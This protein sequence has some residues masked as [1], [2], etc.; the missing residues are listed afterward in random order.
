MNNFAGYRAVC[1]LF[2]AVCLSS[3]SFAGTTP[4]APLTTAQAV[5]NLSRSQAQSGYPVRLHG[6]ITYVDLGWNMMFLHCATGPIFVVL[7]R[8]VSHLR[9]G[10]VVLL[11][12]VTGSSPAGNYGQ[13]VSLRVISK[14]SLPTPKTASLAALSK[15]ADENDYVSTEGILRPNQ[16]IQGHAH[17]LLVDGD[18]SIPIVIPGGSNSAFLRLIGNR[19][20]VH[21][22]AGP[23][24]NAH[25]QRMGT[26]LY[27]Q[28]AKAIQPTSPKEKNFLQAPV[29]SIAS[30]RDANLSQRFLPAVHLRGR[31]LW[32]YSNEF[33][34][35][36]P[37]GTVLVFTPSANQVSSGDD[38]DIVGFPVLRNNHDQIVDARIHFR[39]HYPPEPATPVRLSLAQAL[40]HGENGETAQMSGT[41]VA[42]SQ[43]NGNTIYQVADHR[44]TFEIMAGGKKNA[45]E[46]TPI[47]SPGS[48]IQATGTLRLLPGRNRHRKSV[49]LLVNSP[50]NIVIKSSSGVDWK[51]FFFVITGS[52]IWGIL[53]WV[54]QL[55]RTLRAKTTLI[56]DQMLQEA[57]LED[58]YR[59]LFERSPT[60]IFI[61]QPSGKITDCNPAFARMLEFESP[62]QVIGKSY[63]SLLTD[64][65]AAR[66][67]AR[68]KS[69]TVNDR[70]SG[71]RR[72]DGR[73]AYL[74]ENVTRVNTEDG[75]YYETTALDITQSRLDRIELQ[76]AKIAA[77]REA[78]IDT[79]TGLSN[80]RRFT[81]V[82]KR[83]LE[84]ASHKRTSVA[85]L[86]LDLDGFKAVNDTLGHLIGD[87][88]LQ[89][90]AARLKKHLPAGNLLSRQGGD[91][92]A[93]LL[94][95]GENVADP[96]QVAATLLQALTPP[97]QI[98]GH[99]LTIRAS[100]GISL[101]PNP[102]ADYTNLLQQADSAMYAAK[103]SGRH[104]IVRYN[105]Q[106]GQAL[107][108]KSQITSDLKGAMERREISL[109]Y[110]PE[111]DREN[112]HLVR[113]EALARWSH[114]SLGNIPPIKFISAA[115]ESGLI[116]ELGKYLLE[117]A[118]NDAVNW[119]QKTG[120]A[121]PVAVNISFLQLR[122]D[123]FVEMV[124]NTLKR[125]G[126]PAASLE[127]EMT[128]SVM[129]GEFEQCREVLMS[130]RA[131]GV[132]LA[133]DDFGT[134]YSSLCYLPE[135]PFDRLKI[136]RSFLQKANRDRSGET[137]I[138]AVI[139]IAHRLNLSVVVE[140]IETSRELEFI[141]SLGAD[142]VQGYFLGRPGPDPCSVIAKHS[143]S[144]KVPTG[145]GNKGKTALQ[146]PQQM[147]IAET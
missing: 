20:V 129:L 125:T 98:S 131:F 146:S 114:P 102:A 67:G 74:L 75:Y 97:F 25:E 3:V 44:D 141:C 18:T 112:Q 42:I 138:E 96:E 27:V 88:L 126:L 66:A 113:F 50:R 90:V 101:F 132:Q 21:G 52:F 47:I 9:L 139:S 12:G 93:V 28:S 118:C 94:T 136:D 140:G 49:Q 111:F 77:Q 92:F 106:I 105:R 80:R 115:E 40:R 36:D 119:Q 99:E 143:S 70:E 32:H 68:F 60:G 103:Q 79:L 87:M 35:E 147:H 13:R 17:L 130:L 46:Q 58:K 100:I 5:K 137:L 86:F 109:H 145:V 56:R 78:E 128:E 107:Q 7:P 33:V 122:S 31:V 81:Q 71:L 120:Q 19:V 65:P 116:T 108:E 6:Q 73:T 142:Q 15:G 37:S 61:W 134:G 38:V 89:Q 135:L 82:T 39:R 91:E 133:L 144:A 30:L 117:R 14:K 41:L 63:W 26:V 1:L 11:Q 59:R 8:L 2:L 62:T 64:E 10:D 72:A 83:K 123:G 110:Q 84:Q 43:R 104:R 45:T 24:T 124:L 55:R 57:Q 53:F 54:L 76:R 95:V 22:I 23:R 127:L 51:T 16:P 4:P 48:R 69:G 85:L 34:L 29:V 121:I